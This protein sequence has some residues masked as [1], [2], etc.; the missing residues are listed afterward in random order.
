MMMSNTGATKTTAVRTNR[1]YIDLSSGHG[2]A[3][4]NIALH[5]DVDHV[6]VRKSPTFHVHTGAP[7]DDD[8][9]NVMRDS[10][11]TSTED[12]L[13]TLEAIG[14]LQYLTRLDLVDFEEYTGNNRIGSGSLPILGLAKLLQHAHKLTTLRLNSVHVTGSRADFDAFLQVL[15]TTTTLLEVVYLMD[16]LPARESPH[17]QGMAAALSRL[18]TLRVVEIVETRHA[19]PTS[20]SGKALATLCTSPYLETLRVRGVR[21]LHDHQIELLAQAIIDKSN[22]KNNTS[23]CH[24]KELSLLC[25]DMGPRAVT[26]LC[27]M[28][29]SNHSIEMLCLNRIALH[30]ASAENL[31]HALAHN[32][33]VR[34]LHLYFHLPHQHAC[35]KYNHDYYVSVQDLRTLFLQHCLMDKNYTLEKI[36]GGWA[37]DDIHL[38]CKL[39]TAGRKRLLVSNENGNK[40][41]KHQW[42]NV[43]ASQQDDVRSLYYLLSQ[44]PTLCCEC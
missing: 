2:F 17:L 16:C 37:C 15:S 40:A 27:D 32:T 11:T 10:T 34:Q 33:S 6:I 30:G 4:A 28:L 43:L 38:F 21:W 23:T 41:S 5:H 20:W 35:S 19:P 9:D 25:N 44:N 13:I 1:L 31:A 42:V 26:A 8:D 14:K 7:D 29:R 3:L 18:P 39:N 12:D 36:V 22:S 24:L